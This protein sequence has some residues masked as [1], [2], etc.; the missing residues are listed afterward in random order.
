LW[1][2]VQIHPDI[3]RVPEKGMIAD[4]AALEWCRLICRFFR[5]I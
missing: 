4:V 2:P 3:Q 1:R 5:D